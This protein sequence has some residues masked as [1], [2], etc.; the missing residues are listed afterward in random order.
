M[1]L[2][3]ESVRFSEL[4]LQQVEQQPAPCPPCLPAPALPRL[5]YQVLSEGVGQSKGMETE[6]KPERYREEEGIRE[7]VVRSQVR[8]RERGRDGPREHT[9]SRG[10]AP[11]ATD[12]PWPLGAPRRDGCVGACTQVLAC[13]EVCAAPHLGRGDTEEAG[14]KLGGGWATVYLSSLPPDRE[15]G[16]ERRGHAPLSYSQEPGQNPWRKQSQALSRFNLSNTENVHSVTDVGSL[17]IVQKCKGHTTDTLSPLSP[18]LES[19]P[20]RRP[21][22][23]L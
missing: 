9:C 10:M 16:W 12:G 23:D 3:P 5:T 15:R 13:G 17:H 20:Q 8:V 1:H 4:L 19:L 18:P 22:P 2:G 14:T 7:N 11:S 21:H 6:K